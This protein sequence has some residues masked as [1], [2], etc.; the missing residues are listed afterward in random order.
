MRSS[1]NRILVSHAGNLPRPVELNSLIDDGKAAGRA[2]SDEYQKRLPEA[3][4]GIVDRQIELGVDVVNDGEYAKAGS[5]GGYIHSRVTG[6]ENVPYDASK[7]QKRAGTCR[8][9]YREVAFAFRQL[10]AP[11]LDQELMKRVF[12]RNWLPDVGASSLHR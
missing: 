7:P 6:F 9:E 11:H 12:D 5:Y 1:K 8:G 3:V 4:N 10:I 2:F